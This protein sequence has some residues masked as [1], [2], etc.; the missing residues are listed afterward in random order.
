MSSVL[1]LCYYEFQVQ[2]KSKRTWLGYMVGIVLIINH[3]FS[4]IQYAQDIGESINVL[5]PFLVAAN[6]PNTIVF[7]ILGWL[8]VIS[9]VP[10]ID[11]ISYYA[12]Y[13][14]K[15][16]TWNCAMIL[17]ICLQAVLYYLILLVVTILTSM[18]NGYFA[19][20]WSYTI[21]K[22][23][24][25]VG[26][27]YNINFPYEAFVSGESVYVSVIH[28]LALAVGYAVLMGLL[29]YIVSLIS[30]RN[31]GPVI[32]VLFHFLGYEIMKEGLGITINFSLLARSI[33]AL[34]IGE[35]AL[36][37]I[38]DTY[39]VYAI[40]LMLLF[41]ISQKLIQHIDFRFFCVVEEEE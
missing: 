14:T 10:F 28:T 39:I 19:N 11:H 7:L 40:I 17:Y 6:N 1:K 32:G 33:P 36:T 12:I 5:E 2:M 3:S 21:R 18:K 35:D 30:K 27:E 15:R 25:N 20:I 9:G 4:Y 31:I 34:Q 13:R 29:T 23:I 26:N 16:K 38:L 41:E 24:S 22:V 8:L 37:G